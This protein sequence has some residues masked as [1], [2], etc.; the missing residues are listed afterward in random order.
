M[1]LSNAS[2][3]LCLADLVTTWVASYGA[4]AAPVHCNADQFKQINNKI[5]ASDLLELST[6]VRYYRL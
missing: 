6:S 1:L 2:D 4:S 3:G 5:T